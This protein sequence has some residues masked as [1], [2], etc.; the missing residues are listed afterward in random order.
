[1]VAKYVCGVL[2]IGIS[3]LVYA[4]I[5]IMD[6]NKT[7]VLKNNE[8]CEKIHL[9][10]ATEDLAV[11]GELL[12]GATFD[13]IPCFFKHLDASSSMPGYLISIDP[14]TKSV[15]QIVTHDFPAEFQLNAHGIKL[16]NNKTLY[17]ISHGYAKGGERIHLF[18]LEEIDEDVHATFKE[19]FYFEGDHG[20]Y[21]GIAL[22]DE[23]H[24]YITQ[25]LPFPDLAE[26]RDNSFLVGLKRVLLQLFSSK[27]PVKLCTVIGKSKVKCEPKAFGYMPNGIFYDNKQLFVADSTEK[28]VVIYNVKDNFDLEFVQKVQNDHAVD[29]LWGKDGEIYVAGIAKVIDY[30]KFT[31]AIKKGHPATNLPGGASKIYFKDGKWTAEVIVMQDVFELATS[32]V[33][34]DKIYLASIHEKEILMCPKLS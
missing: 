12:I 13:S 25:W 18:D 29:N 15:K 5:G 26:G 34:T 1:M 30:I 22:V 3:Y 9:P 31:E 16:F 6:I 24:F 10:M 23:K 8:G 27:S 32:V 28:S 11:F 17:V 19:S 33:V 7:L 2:V 14:K 21:N 20:I 4:F